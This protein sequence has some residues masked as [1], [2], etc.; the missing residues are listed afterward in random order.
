MKPN[1]MLRGVGVIAT[2]ALYAVFAYTNGPPTIYSF[3]VA[4]LAVMALISPEAV[5]SFPLG[6]SRDK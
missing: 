2:V 6:P 5:D 3:I 4:A 1:Q